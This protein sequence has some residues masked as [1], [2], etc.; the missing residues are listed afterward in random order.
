MENVKIG[1]K[2]F[3]TIPVEEKKKFWQTPNDIEGFGQLF[4]ASEDQKLEWADLFFIATLPSYARNPRLFS[5]IPQPFRFSI[6]FSL[7]LCL[8]ATM[9][10]IADREK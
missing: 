1:V 6:F 8:L 2:E 9:L 5:N 10:L 4:V 3:L 7:C